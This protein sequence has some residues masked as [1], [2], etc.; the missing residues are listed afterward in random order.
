MQRELKKR[1]RAGLTLKIHAD[2]EAGLSADA[3]DAKY[4]AYAD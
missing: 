3:I 4:P 2:I 1:A